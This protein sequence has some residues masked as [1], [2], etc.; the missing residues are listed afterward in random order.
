MATPNPHGNKHPSYAQHA[1]STPIN[2]LQ[3]PSI[4]TPRSI[5]SPAIHR[6]GASRPPNATKM[7]PGGAAMSTSLSQMSNNSNINTMGPI[8]GLGVMGAGMLGIGASPST[9]LL[10]FNSPAALAG[11]DMITPSALMDTGI[12]GTHAMNLSLSDLGIHSGKRNE[13]EERRLKIESVLGKL[14][15]KRKRHRGDRFGRLSEEGVRRV[16]RWAGLDV[17]VESKWESKE[18]EGRRPVQMAGK[19]TLLDVSS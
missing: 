14:L 7:T 8:V 3:T 18:F 16:G 9:S 6:S 15:G 12:P 2:H 13:D 11:L 10:A 1:V 4:S 17:E 19:N 5:P